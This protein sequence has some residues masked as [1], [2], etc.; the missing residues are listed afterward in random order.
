MAASWEKRAADKRSRIEES[1]PTEWKIQSLPKGD[2]VMDFPE[3]SGILSADEIRITKLSATD[4]VMYL[5]RGELKSVNVTLAF[6]KRAALAHQLVCCLL[7]WKA[8]H[9]L[10]DETERGS[11]LVYLQP[12]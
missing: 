1:I 7:K 3:K 4:L 5:A 9:L 8:F 10:K 6:C 2:S 12:C 11:S